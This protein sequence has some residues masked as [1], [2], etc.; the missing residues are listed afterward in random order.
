[1]LQLTKLDNKELLIRPEY[2]ENI[3]PVKSSEGDYTL[4]I[5]THGKLRDLFRVKQTPDE[6]CQL[7][8]E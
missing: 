4:V 8:N 3:I 6:I 2:I 1:M 7:V 5:V